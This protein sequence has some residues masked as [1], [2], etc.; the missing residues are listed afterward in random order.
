MGQLFASVTM[1]LTFHESSSSSG[2]GNPVEQY[3][4]FVEADSHQAGRYSDFA[5]VHT[6]WLQQQ[7]TTDA[8]MDT[9]KEIERRTKVLVDDTLHNFP[10]TGSVLVLGPNAKLGDTELSPSL[11]DPSFR[12]ANSFLLSSHSHEQIETAASSLKAALHS[13]EMQQ[14]VEGAVREFSNLLAVKFH[15]LMSGMVE[16]TLGLH[17]VH[18]PEDVPVF[19]TIDRQSFLEIHA[20]LKDVDVNRVHDESLGVETGHLANEDTFKFD[21]YTAANKPF[22][23][24]IMHRLSERMFAMTEQM[25]LALAVKAN[26]SP[27]KMAKV[28]ERV[29]GIVADLAEEV[30]ANMCVGLLRHHSDVTIAM[31]ALDAEH[32]TEESNAY[33]EFQSLHMNA[34]ERAVQTVGGEVIQKDAF[35]VEGDDAAI[36]SELKV[37]V[38]DRKDYRFLALRKKRNGDSGNGK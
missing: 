38:A 7:P 31:T 27:E 13:L 16:A 33:G 8:D 9:Y 11:L 14:P 4:L 23:L 10:N 25:Y 32:F 21:D 24:A 19:G 29:K 35:T 1:P 17:E 34:L 20:A 22:E 18:M 37:P 28:M 2:S 15:K 12:D 5:N 6:K 26:L 3:S 36:P 30:A